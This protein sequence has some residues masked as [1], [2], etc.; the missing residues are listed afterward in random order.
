MNEALLTPSQTSLPPTVL[1]HLVYLSDL[2]LCVY[3]CDLC[4]KLVSPLKAGTAWSCKDTGFPGCQKLEAERSGWALT[5]SVPPYDQVALIGAE[6][7]LR[8]K[9]VWC[10]QVLPEVEVL[11]ILWKFLL[12][13]WCKIEPK[14][15]AVK[16]EFGWF[17]SLGLHIAVWLQFCSDLWPHKLRTRNNWVCVWCHAKLLLIWK[18]VE[19]SFTGDSED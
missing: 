5:L 12:G 10:L 11:T 7:G 13:S 2:S 19:T 9:R 1:T 4:Y 18:T 3:M 15:A 14:R 8:T 17:R 16:Q 6:F